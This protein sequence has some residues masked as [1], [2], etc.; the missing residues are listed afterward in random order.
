MSTPLRY[1]ID[2]TDQVRPHVRLC[3]RILS[4]SLAAGFTAVELATPLGGMPTARAQQAG[5]WKSFMAFPPAAYRQ[6]IEHFKQMASIAPQ[7]PNGESTSL[8]RVAGRDAS[9]RV[10]ARRN[11]A[12][13]DE[14]VLHFP[15]TSVAG[16]AT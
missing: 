9:V 11:E 4:E 14:L 2:D 7:E 6:L 1:E 8:V 5:S 15:Q 16:A 13:S 10:Q 12:G 3:H